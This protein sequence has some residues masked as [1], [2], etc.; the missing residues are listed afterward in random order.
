MFEEVSSILNVVQSEARCLDEYGQTHA[1]NIIWGIGEKKFLEDDELEIV[2]I[3][4]GK[5]KSTENSNC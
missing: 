1:T 2:I 4:S 5:M 3:G